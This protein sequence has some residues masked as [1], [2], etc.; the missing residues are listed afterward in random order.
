MGSGE[1]PARLDDRHFVAHRRLSA[2]RDRDLL[3]LARD[4]PDVRDIDEAGIGL[5][6][7]YKLDN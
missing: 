6:E 4:R 7:V 3:H 2:S 5:A 1:V